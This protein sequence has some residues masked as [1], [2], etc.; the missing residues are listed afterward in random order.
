M[1]AVL[2]GLYLSRFSNM[3]LGI[4]AGTISMSV[5]SKGLTAYGLPGSLNNIILGVFIVVFMGITTNWTY[6]TGKLKR[7]ST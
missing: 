1:G 6:L 5:F 3:A 2:V 7:R 4:F